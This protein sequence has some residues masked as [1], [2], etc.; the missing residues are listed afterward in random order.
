MS[1]RELQKGYIKR[2][3]ER[4]VSYAKNKHARYKRGIILIGWPSLNL[5]QITDEFAYLPEEKVKR[6][7]KKLQTTGEVN[8]A[9]EIIQAVQQYDPTW[10][11]V[12]VFLDSVGKSSDLHV[13]GFL[14]NLPFQ[15][16]LMPSSLTA[17]NH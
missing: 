10:Q 2:H 16:L 4:I 1:K 7:L 6:Q 17:T 5:R 15:H 11:T 3:A 14:P 9:D 13:V 8:L 12:I